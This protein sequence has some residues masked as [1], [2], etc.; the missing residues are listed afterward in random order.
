MYPS[1]TSECLFIYPARSTPALILNSEAI[2]LEHKQLLEK[3][4][5][6]ISNVELSS[7]LS[8][9]AST[10]T[11]MNVSCYLLLKRT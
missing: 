5:K 6:L 1:V 10:I 9:F 2:K 11:L 4:I 3:L 8:T 7:D